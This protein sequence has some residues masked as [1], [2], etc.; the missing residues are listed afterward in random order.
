MSRQQSNLGRLTWSQVLCVRDQVL[1]RLHHLCHCQILQDAFAHTDYFAD[2]WQWRNKLTTKANS[3]TM[4]HSQRKVI[5]QTQPPLPIHILS[6]YTLIMLPTDIPTSLSF[7][8]LALCRLLES[9]LHYTEQSLSCTG[10]HDGTA[11][12]WLLLSPAECCR[13]HRGADVCSQ[14]ADLQLFYFTLHSWEK[15]KDGPDRWYSSLVWDLGSVSVRNMERS[16]D[17]CGIFIYV[18]FFISITVPKGNAGMDTV[19]CS[20]V[21]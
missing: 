13:Q 3:K 14:R 21:H 10:K 5:M 8:T 12:W 11:D 4:S 7:F 16:A 6:N 18:F 2:L 1:H 20:S 17:M 19:P 15:K 9:P